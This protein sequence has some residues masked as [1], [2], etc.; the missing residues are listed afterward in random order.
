MEPTERNDN[1]EKNKTKR[2][3]ITVRKTKVVLEPSA[4]SAASVAK[5]GAT[6]RWVTLSFRTGQISENKVMVITY[7]YVTGVG[8]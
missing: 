1:Y 6:R 7:D 2:K 4:V 5:T 3:I 8:P